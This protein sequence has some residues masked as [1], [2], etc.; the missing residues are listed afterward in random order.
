MS[1][2]VSKFQSRALLQ[3]SMKTDLITIGSSGALG[4]HVWAPYDRSSPKN[5]L[6]ERDPALMNTRQAEITVY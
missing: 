5:M 6:F 2:A 4:T 1:I 3:Q